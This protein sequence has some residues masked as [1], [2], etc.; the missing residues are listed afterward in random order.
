MSYPPASRSPLIMN[1]MEINYFNCIDKKDL[2]SR[3]GAHNY[4]TCLNG[5]KVEY[6]QILSSIKKVQKWCVTIN[7][8][9]AARWR[10]VRDL[11]IDDKPVA[12][13]WDHLFDTKYAQ[14][15]RTNERP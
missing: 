12:R 11:F 1:K 9:E 10:E 5:T 3:K 13:A 7:I 8:N 2:R 6:E 4:T 14:E 15:N